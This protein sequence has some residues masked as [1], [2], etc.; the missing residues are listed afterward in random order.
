MTKL[1]KLREENQRLKKQ[2]LRAWELSTLA[3]GERLE[4]L[5]A[6]HENRKLK[7]LLEL[8]GKRR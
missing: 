4:L 3:G 6:A 1:N 7:K 8:A 2:V 5:L